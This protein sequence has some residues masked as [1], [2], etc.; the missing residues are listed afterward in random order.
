MKNLN[1]VFDDLVDRYEKIIEKSF[2][3]RFRRAK[4]KEFVI[5]ELTKETD[6]VLEWLFADSGLKGLIEVFTKRYK[7]G[8]NVDE[9][10]VDLKRIYGEVEDV[11]PFKKIENGKKITL[12]LSEEEKAL[13]ALALDKRKLVKLLIRDTAFRKIQKRLPTMF[14]ESPQTL[15]SAT[16]EIKWTGKKD[17]KNEFVQLVY[18]LHKAGLINAGKGEITKIVENLAEVFKIELGKGWQ[19][20]H[21]SSIHKAKSNYK[22]PVFTKI[23]DAYQK[24][25]DEQIENVKKKR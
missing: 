13:K 11:R 10:I 23:Q 4:D 9:I 1:P 20:N 14:H 2:L 21:S 5:E 19:A 22:P 16:Y 15:L 17:N 3:S 8:D 7:R 18:G 12:Y 25:A 24:Y 6:F